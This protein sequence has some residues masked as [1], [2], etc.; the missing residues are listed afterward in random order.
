MDYRFNPEDEEF[1]KEV[2][3][4]L[5]KTF[6]EDE[7]PLKMET[8][9][10]RVN[11]YRST[12][13]KLFDAGYAG[14][15]Y[16]KKYGGRGGTMIEEIIVAEELAPYGATHGY[17][18]NA[19]GMGMAGPVLNT[20][21]TEEQKLQFLPKLLDGTHIWCQGFSEPNSGS[22]LASVSTRAVR[23]GDHYVVNG[24]KIWTSSAHI[25]DYCML[26]VRTNPDVPKHKGLSYL[27]MDMTLPG[28]D[29]R[30][31]KQLT[32]ESEFCE[33][34]LDDVKIPANMLVGEEDKGWG[35][36]LTTLMFERVMG[37]LNTAN[38]FM[39]EFH[40]ILEMAKD[41]KRSGKPVL[42]NAMIRQKL[43]QAY[44]ELMVLKYNGFRGL[45]EVVQG[46]VPGPQGSIGKIIWSELHQR[47]SELAL[48]I[49][50][51]YN[52][53]M[54]DSAINMD[55]GFWQYTFLRA[56]G[57]TIEAGSAEI[58][59]NIVGERVLGLPKDMA[60]AA[61]KERS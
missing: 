28:V 56:K 8:I 41:V 10:D 25:A 17:G 46:G 57:N 55:D 23:E 1:R 44:I 5:A 2:K 34:F 35:I 18:L 59:R 24:Q 14:I 58:L 43:A 15:R 51:P 4:W 53:L 3:A 52:Q 16:D 40:R 31:V 60:R 50:G 38:A 36:A 13:K 61:L 45:S 7:A 49:E 32:D 27:L 6:P 9:E 37:D 29:V 42:E 54:K 47:M 19:I 11:A 12:Q 20:Q 48:D 22:D 33:V 21:G 30:L 39:R 26:L